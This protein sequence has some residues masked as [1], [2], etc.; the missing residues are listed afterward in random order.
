M[1]IDYASIIAKAEERKNALKQLEELVNEAGPH[2]EAVHAAAKYMH[3]L[4]LAYKGLDSEGRAMLPPELNN[5]L[6]NTHH[7]LEC[8]RTALH[9]VGVATAT[10]GYGLSVIAKFS[11]GT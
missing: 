8:M 2:A 7:T 3:Q 6:G 1:N 10:A 9:R 4:G 11:E 5:A